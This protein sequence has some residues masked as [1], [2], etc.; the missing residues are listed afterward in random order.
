M[1]MAVAA[2]GVQWTATAVSGGDESTVKVMRRQGLGGK[3][4]GGGGTSAI[5]GWKTSHHHMR[6]STIAWRKYI[7]LPP[8]NNSAVGGVKSRQNSPSRV[9]EEKGRMERIVRMEGIGRMGRIGGVNAWEREGNSHI[10]VEEEKIRAPSDVDSV[11]IGI[12]VVDEGSGVDQRGGERSEN[13]QIPSRGENKQRQQEDDDDDE[14]EEEREEEMCVFACTHVLRSASIEE[15]D[16]EGNR[17]GLGFITDRV[18]ND[19]DSSDKS[20]NSD[21]SDKSD[22]SDRYGRLDSIRS[23]LVSAAEDTVSG[24][25]GSS[26]KSDSSSDRYGRSDGVGSVPISTAEDKISAMSDSSDSSDAVGSVLLSTAEDRVSGRFDSCGHSESS[27]D[28]SEVSDRS[29][30]SDDGVGSLLTSTAE[31]NMIS[32]R[33]DNSTDDSDRSDGLCRSDGGA[34]RVSIATPEDKVSEISIISASPEDHAAA[35]VAAAADD[36][37][38]GDDDGGD[39]DGGDGDFGGKKLRRRKLQVSVST[40]TPEDKISE[41]SITFAAASPEDAAAAAA[42][43]ADD[44]DCNADGNADGDEDGGDGGDGGDGDFGGRKAQRKKRRVIVRRRVVVKKRSDRKGDV[45]R[46]AQEDRK[47]DVAREAQEESSIASREEV[48]RGSF[49]DQEMMNAWRVEKRLPVRRSIGVDLGNKRTGIAVTHGGMAPRALE[50]VEGASHAQLAQALL[51][52]AQTEGADEFV[53]GLPLLA[54]GQQSEQARKTRSFVNVLAVAAA[55]RGWRV[56]MF[57]EYSTTKSAM[58]Y[59]LATFGRDAR[60]V[61]PKDSLLQEKVR[62]SLP[63]DPV[64]DFDFLDDM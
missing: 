14:E 20:D 9:W 37:A 10:V 53:V 5:C 18:I 42:A 52:I 19:F 35:A 58:D 62:E 7:H 51:R 17:L 49:R 27:S 26:D 59:M 11:A 44:D 16:E 24:R 33:P 43:A 12:A 8:A 61:W 32:G 15:K 25:S 29:S 3:G 22:K 6:R 64:D 56:L 46:E 40:P 34:G 28:R 41:I 63:R 30:R 54:N 4:G 39:D 31:E 47:G 48:T 38:D 13:D 21:N 23:V 55:Q 45:A 50:V 1:A 57:D 2:G 36:D 60:M